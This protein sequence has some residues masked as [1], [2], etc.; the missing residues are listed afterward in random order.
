MKLPNTEDEF[1]V[2]LQD[3]GKNAKAIKILHFGLGIDEYNHIYGSS[4]AWRFVA[5]L[6]WHMNVRIRNLQTYEPKKIDKVVEE[7]KKERCLSLKVESKSDDE[8]MSMFVRTFEKFFRK[9]NSE[10]RESCN[11]AFKKSMKATWGETSYEE[12]KGEDDEKDNLA[13]MAKSDTDSDNN[14]IELCRKTRM[15]MKSTSFNLQS[16]RTKG[17]HVTSREHG[18]S[19]PSPSLSIKTAASSL[20]PEEELT[21]IPS[22]TLLAPIDLA[23]LIYDIKNSDDPHNNVSL[24]DSESEEDLV[25]IEALKKGAQK[26][27]RRNTQGGT[28]AIPKPIFPQ[29]KVKPFSERK[30]LKGKMVFP[31]SNPC[32]TE[33]WL[34]I[35]AQGWNP[36]FLDRNAFVAKAE[37][38][39]DVS[40]NHAL[41]YRFLLTKVFA[42]LGVQFTSL[43]HYSTYDALDYFETRGSR[44]EGGMGGSSGAAGSS[45]SKEPFD[46]DTVVARHKDL[47]SLIR[48]L[49]PSLAPS[50]SVS[51]PSGPIP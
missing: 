7:P 21:G 41:P 49:S 33:L 11:K 38:V 35:E 25:P 42:K 5:L 37:V 46:T 50:S 15:N 31:S 24:S 29:S 8:E 48:S 36:L 17:T 4:S 10:K 27:A 6:L 45:P 22:P 14:S 3:D 40:Q 1:D 19:N 23:T 30:L 20:S 43:E 9:E 47:I 26:R 28:T 51:P 39:I 34:K 32:L 44:Q 13:L 16:N 18:K 2:E 12:S